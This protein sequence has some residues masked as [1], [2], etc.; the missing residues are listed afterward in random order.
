MTMKY[1]N[2]SDKAKSVRGE[3]FTSAI[4]YIKSS[5]KFQINNWILLSVQEKIIRGQD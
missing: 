1:Q 4:N 3:C 2:L 5:E